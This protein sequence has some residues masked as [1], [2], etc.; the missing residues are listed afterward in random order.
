[1]TQEKSFAEEADSLRSEFVNF[2]ADGDRFEG[3]NLDDGGE[4]EVR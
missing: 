2:F 3:W 1:M 4:A